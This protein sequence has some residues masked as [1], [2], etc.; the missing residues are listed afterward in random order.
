VKPGP[1]RIELEWL[2]Y[3]GVRA[4]VSRLDDEEVHA[5]GGWLGRTA[6]LVAGRRDRLA[7]S[8]LSLAFPDWSRERIDEVRA[9]CWEHFGRVAADYLRFESLDPDAL[10]SRVAIE[11]EE[12]LRQARSR[13]R[14]VFLLSAHLGHWEIG[15]LVAGLLGEPI[16][17]IARTLDNPKLEGALASHRSRCG[18]RVVPKR[19]AAREMLRILRH[20]G[21]IAILADQKVAKEEAIVVPFFGRPARTTPALARIAAR[22][23]AAIVPVFCRPEPNAGPGR[24]R[25]VF[26]SAIVPSELSEVERSP[27]ALTARFV[28]ITER[29]IRRQPE[30]WLWMHD[31]WR[32]APA[33]PD[34]TQP[35]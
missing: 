1:I 25:L 19:E 6:R 17:V 8:N 14:G 31:R 27:E 33:K 2:A 34:G 29:A 4:L 30:L 26:E 20:G 22:I 13:G 5:F 12:H 9:R 16:A 10:R 35:S 18:N 7:F 24:Y 28:E 32:G 23:D 15:A 11:G 3:R 21:T